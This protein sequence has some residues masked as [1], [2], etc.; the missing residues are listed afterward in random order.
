MRGFESW[1]RKNMSF[2]SFQKKMLNE[3]HLFPS[4]NFPSFYCLNIKKIASAYTKTG[5][6][7]TNTY[8]W[9]MKES[10]RMFL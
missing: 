10:Q 7:F 4:E 9:R 5:K 6:V 2:I 1:P 3:D 8:I